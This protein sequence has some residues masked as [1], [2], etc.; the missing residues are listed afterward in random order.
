MGTGYEVGDVG[1]LMEMHVERTDEKPGWSR[2]RR[3][4]AG[5]AEKGLS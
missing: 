5:L 3:A 4:R 2:G 1:G